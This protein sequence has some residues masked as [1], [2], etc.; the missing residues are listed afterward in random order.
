MKLIINNNPLECRPNYEY[1]IVNNFK[2]MILLNK[3]ELNEQIVRKGNK[4]TKYLEMNLINVIRIWQILNNLIN[5]LI[6]SK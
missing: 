6:N 4:I 5:K 2:S 3:I 1:S